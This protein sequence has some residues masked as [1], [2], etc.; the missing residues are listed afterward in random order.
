[1][2]ERE[3]PLPEIQGSS[4]SHFP[5]VTP[6]V[7]PVGSGRAADSW[8]KREGRLIVGSFVSQSW[9]WYVSPLLTFY[10]PLLISKFSATFRESWKHICP[11]GKRS[12]HL[13]SPRTHHLSSCKHLFHFFAKN[14]IYSTIHTP[15]KTAPNPVNSIQPL[16]SAQS[17][18][19]MFPPSPGSDVGKLEKVK[20]QKDGKVVLKQWLREG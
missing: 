18:G 17:P 13:L 11:W 7:A 16:H 8:R 4:L 20:P 2:R 6:Q 9:K 14:K 1:M 19:C 3:T 5:P 12:E 10:W 15:R